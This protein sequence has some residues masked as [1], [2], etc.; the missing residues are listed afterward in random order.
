MK[1][2]CSLLL[3]AALLLSLTACGGSDSSAKDNLYM[4]QTASGETNGGW[5]AGTENAKDWAKQEEARDSPSAD[6]SQALAN[7]KM[8]YTADLEL[9][10]KAFDSASQALDQIVEGLGGYYESR[11]LR[12]GGSY[13][14]L[15][16]TIRIPAEAFSDFLSQAGQVA[17]VTGQN[18]YKDDVSEAYYDTEARLKTQQTKL[19]RLHALLEQ[20]ATMEDIIALETALSETELQ[21]EYLTGS[22]RHYDSLIGYSTVNLYLREV[23]KLSTDDQVPET[24][25]QRLAAAF[26]TGFRRGVDGLEDLVVSLA[27]NWMGLT[28]LALVLTAAVVL[29]RR[30]WRKRTPPPPPPAEDTGSKT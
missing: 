9:E 6:I 7:A 10:T 1:R 13:R 12:Q 11:S 4:T 5:A 8:I 24:F 2:I 22:L 26:S 17:H 3:A 21:I 30:R 19:D 23:Y 27:R 15:D 16:C 20:A 29:L 28:V 18:E 14:S 25:D